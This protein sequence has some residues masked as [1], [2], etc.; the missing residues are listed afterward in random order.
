MRCRVS[1]PE[2]PLR[3]L[4]RAEYQDLGA[5]PIYPL[6]AFEHFFAAYKELEGHYIHVLG[7]KD[8][9]Q[10][11]DTRFSRACRTRFGSTST[12]SSRRTR[13]WIGL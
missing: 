9:L 8:T 1:L 2:T 5:V 11:L 3:K 12:T 7:W 10:V 6:T 4:A 13:T